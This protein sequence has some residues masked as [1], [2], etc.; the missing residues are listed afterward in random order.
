MPDKASAFRAEEGQFLC[1]QHA[2]TYF[3]KYLDTVPGAED[4]YVPDMTNVLSDKVIVTGIPHS[5][6]QITGIIGAFNVGLVV[7][8]TSLPLVI[9]GE[10]DSTRFGTSFPA[11]TEVVE[12]ERRGIPFYVACMRAISEQGVVFLHLPTKDLDPLPLAYMPLLQKSADAALGAGKGV[13]LQCFY[14]HYRIWSAAT[15]V[16]QRCGP[17]PRP[18]D[19]M[20]FLRHLMATHAPRCLQDPVFISAQFLREGPF[21]KVCR[22]MHKWDRDAQDVLWLLATHP[23]AHAFIMGAADAADAANHWL[24][25]LLEERA[26]A[27]ERVTVQ[28]LL[29]FSKC[30]VPAARH[31]YDMEWLDKVCALTKA[32]IVTHAPRE[33]PQPSTES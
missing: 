21:A 6:K 5:S 23:E 1:S 15:F 29:S 14:G 7:T 30:D 24:P 18:L 16:L 31:Y 11:T 12:R 28:S 20:P 4:F 8:L 26:R 2:G 33:A 9:P 22:P 17:E 13:W 32:A 3:K 10:P 25:Q 27:S 19:P